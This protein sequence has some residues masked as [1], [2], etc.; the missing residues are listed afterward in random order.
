MSAI[1]NTNDKRAVRIDFAPMVDLGFLLITFFVF[2]TSLMEPKAFGLHMPEDGIETQAP[3]SATITLTLLENGRIDYLEGS[4]AHVLT[5]GSTHLYQQQSL[6]KHLLEKRE[7]IIEQL[8]SDEQ[9][10]VLIQP[11]SQTNYK[12]MVDVLDEMTITGI[13]KY[14]LLQDKAN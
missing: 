9:Y 1:E 12:E 8:G 11:T 2:T 7:R 6:R 14:V 3:L 5:K 13:K 4:E 10:T